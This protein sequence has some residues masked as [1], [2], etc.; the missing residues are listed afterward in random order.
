MNVR[1][2]ESVKARMVVRGRGAM[3]GMLMYY[4]LE[5]DTHAFFKMVVS[6][7]IKKI[8]RFRCVK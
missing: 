2:Q 7:G 3:R 6:M 1:R 4:Q 5:G 8:C